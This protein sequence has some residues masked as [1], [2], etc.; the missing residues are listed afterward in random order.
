MKPLL[1]RSAIARVAEKRIREAI[2]AGELDDLPGL[3]KPIAGIDEPY[4]PLWWVKGWMQRVER[5]HGP[6]PPLRSIR[7]KRE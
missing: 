6:L 7:G 5:E 4:D 1:P 3:G 2:E